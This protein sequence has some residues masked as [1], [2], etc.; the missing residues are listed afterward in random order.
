MQVLQVG[1][2]AYR[3]ST[4]GPDV[5]LEG[6]MA[7]GTPNFED[8]PKMPPFE[9]RNAEISRPGRPFFRGGG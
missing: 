2:A 9:S 3:V 8:L 1:L 6:N 5:P 7:F 4:R